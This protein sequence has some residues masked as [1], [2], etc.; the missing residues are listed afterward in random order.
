MSDKLIELEALLPQL[1]PAVERRQIGESLTRA[2]EKLRDSGRQA[3]R[4]QAVLDIAR[5][6]DFRSDAARKEDFDELLEETV[7]LA[8]DL[9][10]ARTADDLRD[11]CNVYDDFVKHLSGL[12]RQLRAHWRHRAHE[13]FRPLIAIGELLM[14]LDVAAGLG[15]QLVECGREAIEVRDNIPAEDLRGTI[16]RVRDRQRELEKERVAMTSDTEVDAFLVALAEG[17]ATLRL[18]TAR[19]RSWLDEN[20][21][22]DRFGI[23]P[24]D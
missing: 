13:E 3:A 11:A 2:A 17:R 1:P 18:V 10:R 12:D 5:E 8:D 21:A 7:A 20:D 23:R 24:A 22:L 9:E 4:L 16:V 14:K 19:V 6:T 15:R